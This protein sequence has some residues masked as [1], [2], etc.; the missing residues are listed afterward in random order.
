VFMLTVDF[1]DRDVSV[2]APSTQYWV[3]LATAIS[4]GLL[5]ATPLTLLFTP[6][7][8]VWGDS[9]QGSTVRGSMRTMK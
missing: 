4:G 5:V 1:L 2:G 3:Q 8:L 6:V 9:S 7:M